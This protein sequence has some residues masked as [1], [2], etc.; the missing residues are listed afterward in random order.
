MLSAFTDPAARPHDVV[1]LEF[2]RYE[3]DHDGWGGFQPIRGAHDGQHKL[4]LNLLSSDELYDLQSD[5]QELHNLLDS[6][7]HAAVRDRLHAALLAWMNETRD[8][9]RGPCWERRPWQSHRT[10]EWRGPM[11]LRPDD[12]YQRRVVDYLTG[13][14][15]D[16]FVIERLSRSGTQE[17]QEAP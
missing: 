13:Q 9:F 4:T 7:A 11:R 5:P 8:P 12:G 17:E 2:N 1:F 3:V 16:G 14:E 6:P 10:M 15:V